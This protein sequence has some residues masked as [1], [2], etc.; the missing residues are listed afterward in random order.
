MKFSVECR[1]VLWNVTNRVFLKD[2]GSAACVCGALYVPIDEIKERKDKSVVKRR[3]QEE[4]GEKGML[5]VSDELWR[6]IWHSNWLTKNSSHFSFRLDRDFYA[7]Q[8]SSSISMSGL[9]FL[10]HQVKRR[11]MPP[12]FENRSEKAKIG[13][14]KLLPR[15]SSLAH[16]Y[17]F[18]IRLVR[19]DATK[20]EHRA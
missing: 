17:Q 7:G 16:I 5:N 15:F 11:D 19:E 14:V 3:V 20:T 4:R 6:I 1:R 8:V 18:S 9:Y 2:P 13:T 12:A 10:D